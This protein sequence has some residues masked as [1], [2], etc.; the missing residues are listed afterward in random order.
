MSSRHRQIARH[1]IADNGGPNAASF[2][3]QGRKINAN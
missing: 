3:R 2:G 1:G